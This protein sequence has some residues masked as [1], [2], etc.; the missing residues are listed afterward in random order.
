MFG[1]AK[2]PRRFILNIGGYYFLLP[3]KIDSV[4]VGVIMT[5]LGESVLVERDW[6]TET[7]KLDESVR[8]DFELKSVPVEKIA[9]SSGPLPAVVKPAPSDIPY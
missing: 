1:A 8:H 7:W 3:E 9:G 2:K 4:E 5:A 6:K